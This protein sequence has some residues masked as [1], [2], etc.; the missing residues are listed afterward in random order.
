M[1][2][3][4]CDS[5]VVVSL[6]ADQPLYYTITPSAAGTVSLSTCDAATDVDTVRTGPAPALA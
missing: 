3:L 5:N 4:A 2:E 1:P 6:P